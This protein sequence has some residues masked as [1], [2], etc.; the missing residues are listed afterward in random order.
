MSSAID[1]LIASFEDGSLRADSDVNSTDAPHPERLASW[2]A[3]G[4]S[5]SLAA[6]QK[7]RRLERLEEQRL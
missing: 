5:T 1:D 4:V 2:K 3:T 7:K 6:S